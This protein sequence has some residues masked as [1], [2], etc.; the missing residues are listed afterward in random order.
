LKK[1]QHNPVPNFV[2]RE[3]LETFV[4]IGRAV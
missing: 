1:N 4:S 3:N 2:G